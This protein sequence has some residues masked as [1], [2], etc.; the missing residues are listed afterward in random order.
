MVSRALMTPVLSDAGVPT[1]GELVE[2][3]RDRAYEAGTSGSGPFSTADEATSAVAGYE[4]YLAVIGRHLRVIATP[5]VSATQGP[6]DSLPPL[7]QLIARMRHLKLET[8]SESLWGTAAD[9]LATAH[10]LLATH[11]GPFGERR[12]PEVEVLDDSRH[13]HATTHLVLALLEEP[14]AR[15]DDLL[16]AV[17]ASLHDAQLVPSPRAIA[18]HLRQSTDAIVRL[19]DRYVA[20][21][22]DPTTDAAAVADLKPAVPS[23]SGGA[24]PRTLED[25]MQALRVLR[26]LSFRQTTGGEQASPGSLHDLARLARA[27]TAGADQWLPPAQTPIGRVQRANALDQLKRA[28]N[29]WQD[30]ATALGQHIRGLTKAPRLYADAIGAVQ[31]AHTHETVRRAV[32]ASL[33]RLGREAGL[34]TTRLAQSSSLAVATKDVGRF[35]ESWRLLTPDESQ[36][37]AARFA[38]SGETSQTASI[39]V[40]QLDRSTGRR[41]ADRDASSSAHL[42]RGR[43]AEERTR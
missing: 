31:Q 13:R 4:R 1:Y 17:T 10:D 23:S 42:Q 26:V 28:T 14:L 27:T 29:A 22:A 36:V 19:S 12:T 38:R 30:A 35:Q 40:T 39:S 7:H 41:P 16:R 33:P 15:R 5:G 20:S 24:G 18:A 32:L 11:L 25:S 9:T 37:L 2:L 8:S 34:T 43:V 3:A 21:T 6:L